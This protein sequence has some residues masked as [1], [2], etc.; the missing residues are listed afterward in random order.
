MKKNLLFVLALAALTVSCKKEVIT[1]VEGDR[2]K[3]VMIQFPV[4]VWSTTNNSFET[5]PNYSFLIDFDKRDYVAVD[6]IV[7]I[8]GLRSESPSDTATVRLF[9]VTDNSAIANSVISSNMSAPI[10]QYAVMQSKNVFSSL[11][12]KRITLAVQIKSAKNTTYVYVIKP[13]LKLRRK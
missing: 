13:Y 12:D 2:D 1:Y 11:P 5:L 10:Q 3:E 7:L 8:A 6:S 9:N 4:W